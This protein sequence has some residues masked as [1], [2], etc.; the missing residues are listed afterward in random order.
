MLGKDELKLTSKSDLTNVLLTIYTS[1]NTFGDI[2]LF[3]TC[4]IYFRIY[5]VATGQFNIWTKYLTQG[6]ICRVQL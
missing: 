2:I 4:K 5:N 6:L 3:K 1:A